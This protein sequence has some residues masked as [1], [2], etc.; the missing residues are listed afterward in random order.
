MCGICGIADIAG[1][2]MD[3]Q[4]LVSR[5]VGAIQ[6]RGPDGSEFSK[7]DHVSFGFCRL[8]IIDLNVS[9]MQPFFNESKEIMMVCNG[10]IYN[11]KELRAHLVREGH[12]FTSETDVE[13][14]LHLY[15]D[16]GTDFLN[17]LNGQFAF[18]IY[19][20]KRKKLFCARDQV[21]IAP[22]FYTFINE[23]LC[24]ASEIKA[25]LEIPQVK[26]TVNL[27]ALDQMMNFPGMV[28]NQTMFE[29]IHSL[30]NGHYITLDCCTGKFSVNE[31]WDMIYPTEY[32]QTHGEEYYVE[33]LDELLTQSVKLRLQADVPVGFYISG[34]LDSSI[35]AAAIKRWTSRSELYSFSID[36]S[37]KGISE[38]KYQQM[39]ADYVQSSHYQRLITTSDID[40]LLRKAVYHSES[41]LKETYNTASLALSELVRKHGIKVVLTG[42]GADELFGGYVGYRFDKLRQSSGEQQ[43]ISVEEREIRRRIWGDESFFYER[44]YDSFYSIK[45]Q[46]FSRRLV[47]SWDE[48]DSLRHPVI[49]KKR[50]RGLDT[51]HKRSYVDYKLRLPEHLLA[52]H[53]DR[54][55]YANSVEARYPFLDKDLIEFVRTI[56]QELKLNGFQEKYILKKYARKRVPDEIIKRPKFA[57]VAPGSPELLRRNSEFIQDTLSSDRIKR[58][59]FFNPDYIETL[60]QQYREES[61]KL[62]LPYDHDLLILAITFNIFMDEFR[63]SNL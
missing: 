60:K 15:E 48:I 11:Y 47:E 55:A 56:P 1:R 31:Y 59:G 21:G 25:L 36:F 61:F 16:Y 50:L 23:S 13:V 10:E 51:F 6:H 40:S 41:P 17:M 42:E 39:M 33:K 34:G 14:V 57:F 44:N 2:D 7:L 3:N 28:G 32:E 24:F 46:F 29:G 38:A 19:D 18:A 58:D 52:D 63:V 62:N 22:F 5:M 45:K 9:G 53:G 30:E 20:S 54:M 8:S 37:Q 26:R 4:N 43:P 12:R 35:I 49:N 27:V